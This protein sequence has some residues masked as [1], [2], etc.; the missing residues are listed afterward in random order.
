MH[1][2]QITVFIEVLLK[3][4]ADKIIMLANEKADKGFKTGVTTVD[5]HLNL[6]QESLIKT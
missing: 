3:K 6:Y 2:K 4:V 1:R 5:Q